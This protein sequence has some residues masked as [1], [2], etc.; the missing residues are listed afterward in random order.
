[1]LSLTRHLR[2]W[3]RAPFAMGSVLPSSQ[4][5]AMAM[6]GQIDANV[7]G[8]IVEL[9]AG[10]GAITRGLVA[11]GIAPER[12]IILERDAA[13]HRLL[14]ARFPQ[15]NVV[16]A[17][18]QD[19]DKMLSGAPVSAIVSSL[20]LLS[21]PR[22]SQTLV[23]QRMAEAIGE[24]GRIIQFTYGPK[25]PISERTRQQYRL[26]GQKMKTVLANVPP[27]RV[28]VYRKTD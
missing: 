10:T 20:P 5:L 12:F 28:W 8:V 13:L 14:Q 7:P 2:A 17:D 6:A 11:S 18:A 27:A 22:L 21:M 16:C 19:L 1:M 25:S 24:Q 9:G 23:E 4:A 26:A 3:L 15:L